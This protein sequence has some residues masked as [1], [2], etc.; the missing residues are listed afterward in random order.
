MSG[1]GK[2]FE[3]EIIE[4]CVYYERK[5]YMTLRKVDPPTRI[6]KFGRFPKIIFLKNPFLDFTGTITEKNGRAIYLEAK[7]T[8]EDRIGISCKTNGITDTQMHS[9]RM[10][11]CSKAVSAVLWKCPSGVFL[12]PVTF[13]DAET[14]RTQMKHIKAEDIPSPYRCGTSPDLKLMS[15]IRR[16]F[17]S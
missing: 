12:L 13:I 1:R 16:V 4:R 2:E 5:R 7:E 15:A 9:L 6:V 14:D 3:K 17:K 11:H 8:H 10:W